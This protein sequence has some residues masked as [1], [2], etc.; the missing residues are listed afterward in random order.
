MKFS[1]FLGLATMGLSLGFFSACSTDSS[2]ESPVLTE[3]RLDVATLP[4]DGSTSTTIRG[5]VTDDKAGFKVSYKVLMGTTDKSSD[6]TVTSTAV[7]AG[8]TS[9]SLG[10]PAEGNGKITAKETAASG[11]YTLVITVK[12]ADSSS[13]T[14]SVSLKVTGGFVEETLVDTTVS[15]G[16]Y[17]SALASSIDLD[18]MVT[19]T[20]ALAKANSSLIDL[21]FNNTSDAKNEIRAPSEDASLTDWTT[22]N[23]TTFHKVAAGSYAAATT[24]AKVEALYVAASAQSKQLLIEEGDEIVVKTTEG[25]FV[26][27]KVSIT[28]DSGKGTVEFSVKAGK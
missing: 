21:R 2:N 13:T 6:F 23:A 28:K 7:K 11:D 27:I 4:A 1:R 3:A 24:E 9:W 18:E 22:K 20:S 26:L 8:V 14:Q 19:Y 25:K 12:D 16:G 17:Q 15:L 5:K 10:D